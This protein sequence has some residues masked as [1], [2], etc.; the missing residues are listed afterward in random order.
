MCAVDGSTAVHIWDISANGASRNSVGAGGP[1][2]TAAWGGTSKTEHAEF[3]L[4]GLAGGGLEVWEVKCGSGVPFQ[5]S[6]V[7][8][9]PPPSKVCARLKEFAEDG[10][11]DQR[12]V[13]CH[14]AQRYSV[15]SSDEG[16][17]ATGAQTWMLGFILASDD[18]VQQPEPDPVFIT[19][20]FSIE[21]F[22]SSA[23]QRSCS[24]LTI[25]YDQEHLAYDDMFDADAGGGR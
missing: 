18:P 21:S 5:A 11:W 9:A 10:D 22:A 16:T 15:D 20:L 7:G 8:S 19:A 12:R 3:L 13:H 24:E 14:F 17:V 4:I 25:A 6:K 23:I 2:T 1:V